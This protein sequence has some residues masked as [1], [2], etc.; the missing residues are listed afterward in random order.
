[1]A[2]SPLVSRA[3]LSSAGVTAYL[4]FEFWLLSRPAQT[5]VYLSASLYRTYPA[6]IIPA[7]LV[8]F[9]GHG[10]VVGIVLAVVLAVCALW[11]LG[12]LVFIFITLIAAT[13][14]RNFEQACC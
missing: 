11:M 10:M 4:Y 3:A 13:L 7:F 6:G 5:L 8:A 2:G 9:S 14:R 12:W 1:M